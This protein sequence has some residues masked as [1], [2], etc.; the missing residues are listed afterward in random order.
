M[1][2]SAAL[3]LVVMLSSCF[4]MSLASPASEWMSL[5]DQAGARVPHDPRKSVVRLEALDLEL[6]V[7]AIYEGALRAGGEP[8]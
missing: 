4:L 8:A 1:P 5:E 3:T 7:T 6:S 2:A